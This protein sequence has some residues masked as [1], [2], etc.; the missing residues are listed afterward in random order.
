MHGNMHVTASASGPHSL[1]DVGWL[2]L[3]SAQLY[4]INSR[5]ERVRLDSLDAVVLVAQSP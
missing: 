3:A 2:V 5:K 4:P 1:W